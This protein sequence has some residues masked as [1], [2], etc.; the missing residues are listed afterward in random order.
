M[1]RPS[2]NVVVGSSFLANLLSIPSTVP[3]GA[4]VEQTGTGQGIA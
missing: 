1:S 2:E 3:V 4:F